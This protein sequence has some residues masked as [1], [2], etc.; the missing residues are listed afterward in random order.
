MAS[1]IESQKD[2]VYY[3]FSRIKTSLVTRVVTHHISLPCQQLVTGPSPRS[4]LVIWF[5]FF[6]D[7]WSLVWAVPK[8]HQLPHIS[9]SVS[10]PM[11]LGPW[12]RHY[13]CRGSTTSDR[14][15]L[16]WVRLRS[17]RTTYRKCHLSLFC[18]ETRRQETRL[19]LQEFEARWLAASR[20]TI[21]SFDYVLSWRW[22]AGWFRIHW[23]L[24]KLS[25]LRHPYVHGPAESPP[26]TLW[27]NSFI[28]TGIRHTAY[29]RMRG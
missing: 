6:S 21:F 1:S 29:S 25:R 23:L 26:V 19:L 18:T 11:G 24:G 20:I 15:H 4:I 2:N 28:G 27:W 17:Q 5:N 10:R 3:L 7:D 12:A 22:W 16:A 9:H 8:C 14:L 13:G